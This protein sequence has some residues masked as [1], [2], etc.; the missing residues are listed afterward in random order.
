MEPNELDK[1]FREVI[2]NDA[3]E[4]TEKE[5]SSKV[6]IWKELDLPTK[7]KK[8]V[9]PFWKVAG[10]IL[11]LVFSGCLW[12]MLNNLQHQKANYAQLEE[13]YR[14]IKKEL[15][16]IEQKAIGAKKIMNDHPSEIIAKEEIITKNTIIEKEFIDRIVSVRDTV[17]IEK[18]MDRKETIKLV[19][20]TIFIKVPAKTPARWT[21]LEEKKTVKEDS[22]L[23]KKKPSKIEFVFDKEEIKKPIQEE[24]LFLWKSEFA[25]KQKK[26]KSKNAIFS[27]PDNNQ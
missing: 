13:D 4:I 14:E 11:F 23:S 8:I 10:G 2:H 12:L 1:L 17:W 18:M 22:I 9:F 7:N 20:D 26:K 6:E 19:R 24:S 15:F 3:S 27:V 25:K 21:N 16:L 5:K